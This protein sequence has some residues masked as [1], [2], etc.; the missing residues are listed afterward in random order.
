M[1]M[2][3]R[4]FLVSATALSAGCGPVTAGLGRRL[5]Q[6]SGT[7]TGDTGFDTPPDTTWTY[8]PGPEPDPWEPEGV[9]D[10]AL[11]PFGIQAGDAQFDSVVLSVRTRE[12]RVSLTLVRGVDAGWEVALELP[13]L[14][15]DADVVQVEIVDLVPDTTY[16]YAFYVDDGRRSLPGRLRTALY[17]GQNR[18]VRFGATSCLGGNQPWPSLTRASEQLLDFFVLLGDTIYADS[19]W[20]EPDYE[21]DW[22]TALSQSGLQDVT[23]STSVIATWDDHEVDNNWSLEEPGMAE[24]ALEALASFRRAIPMIQGTEGS[25]L[26][27]RLTWGDTLE[28]F[29]L[30]CRGERLGGRYLSVEQ[31]AWLKDGLLTS[32]ARFKIICNSVPITDM[33]DV[34]FGVAAN[35]R[36][37]G[38]PA[39]R[40]E[41]LDHIQ[42][43]AIEGILFIAGDFHW[44]ASCSVGRPG[45][46]HDNLR[47]VFCGPGGSAI[48]PLLIVFNPPAD[49]YDLVIKRFNY[50]GFECDPDAGTVRLAFIGDDGSVIDEQVLSL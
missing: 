44:G 19:G 15:A 46:A 16:A 12:P 5:P 41:L 30:D 17:P 6:A 50:V 31:M 34:Y 33:D 49:H 40:A 27:R 32:A 7:D 24:R 35:D 45:T 18:V 21:G 37:D 4:R 26:W 20:D 36:W 42:D 48:N 43:N 39:D 22:E 29:V 28:V 14:D 9:F 1:R 38:H 11:F 3:R 8:G 13:D 23:A 10:P 2:T 25:T 47:E